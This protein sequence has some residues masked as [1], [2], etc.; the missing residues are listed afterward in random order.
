[1]RVAIAIYL[2]HNYYFLAGI[3][4]TEVTPVITTNG[5]TR[6]SAP[7]PAFDTAASAT[8]SQNTIVV[9]ETSTG[10][11]LHNASEIVG[12]TK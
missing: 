8:T 3:A 10:E 7:N 11:T 5:Y 9:A 12:S 2:T 1:L 6:T 4:V